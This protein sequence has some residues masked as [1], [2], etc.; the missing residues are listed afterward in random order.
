MEQSEFDKFADEYYSL[1]VHNIVMSGESPEYFAEYK[2]RDLVDIYNA[3]QGC[4]EAP[5]VLDFGAG[6]GT[7]VPFMRR[8]MPRA[9][10]TCVDVSSKSLEIGRAR[11]GGVA[12]F[13]LLDGARVPFP[14]ESFDMVFA[15]C[16]FH[17]ID[18]R[19]HV[20]LLREM[21]RVLGVGRSYF[22]LRAQP[23]Q[24]D[25][26]SCSKHLSVRR[27]CTSDSGAEHATEPCC[28]WLCQ[29]PD[30]LS[31]LFPIVS[32]RS[33]SA[34]ALDHLVAAWCSI[35][36]RSIQMKPARTVGSDEVRNGDFMVNRTERSI[37]SDH[38]CLYLF[39]FLNIYNC[40]RR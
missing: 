10:L 25:H 21:L 32:P 26:A 28:S 2:I 18:Q 29:S 22:S 40:L 9:R 24:S 8:Y 19:E 12:E 20:T 30:A 11:F 34:R 15:A 31:C 13:V 38:R 6:V 36:R 7:S 4:V 27:K 14:D 16:V 5:C 17:H 23:L 37:T 39:I 35:L 1:H 33:A 3:S